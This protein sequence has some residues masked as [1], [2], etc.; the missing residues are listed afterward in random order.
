MNPILAQTLNRFHTEFAAPVGSLPAPPP[1]PKPGGW[2][3]LTDDEQQ[4]RII[5]ESGLKHRDN[6]HD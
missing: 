3:H 5:A 6:N 2:P 1:P 4:A